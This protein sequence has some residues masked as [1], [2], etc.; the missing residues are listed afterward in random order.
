MQVRNLEAA[1]D[2]VQE[3]FAKVWVSSNTPRVESEFKRWLYRSIANLAIDHQRREKRQPIQ[4]FPPERITGAADA[5]ELMLSRNALFE[6]MERLPLRDRQLLY[7]RYFEDRPFAE[8]AR[9]LGVH[10][11]SARVSVLRALTKLKRQLG[12]LSNKETVQNAS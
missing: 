3:A 2:I 12:A 5:F 8:C 1:E 7:L 4:P 9:L 6:A 11:V 10:P